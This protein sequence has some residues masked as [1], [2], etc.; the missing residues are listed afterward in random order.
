[1]PRIVYTYRSSQ[2]PQ[3]DQPNILVRLAIGVLSVVAL[4]ASALFGLFIFLTALGVVA[5]AGAVLAV[6]F[7][8]FRRKV[9]AALKH[10]AAQDTQ[11]RDYIDAEYE[12]R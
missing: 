1:M 4:I 6:R 9:E 2:G 11:D 8:L 7:W 12:E 3:G 5:V 10:G